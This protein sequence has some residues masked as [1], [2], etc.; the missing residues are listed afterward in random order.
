[1]ENEENTTKNPTAEDLV[2]KPSID[3]IEKRK[4]KLKNF[5]FGWIKDNYDK[6]FIVIIVIAFII[7]FLIFLKTMDQPIWYDTANYLATGKKWGLGLDIRDVWYYRRAFLWPAMAAVIFKIGLGEVSLRFMTVLFSTGIVFVSYFLIKELFS[8]RLAL[9]VSICMS[10][11]W[12]ILFFTAR[13]MTSIPATFFALLAILFFLKG[14]FKEQKTSYMALFGLFYGLAILTRMQYLMLAP[15]FVIFAFFKEKFKFLKNK[16]LWI[17]VIIFLVVLTPHL[18]MYN[19]HY[20][21]PFKDM[22]IKYLGIGALSDNPEVELDEKHDV[23]FS[24]LFKYFF[25]LP[26]VLTKPMLILFIIGVFFFFADLAL[27]IDKVFKNKYLQ[28]KLFVFLIIVVF[29]IV[30]AKVAID[31]VEQRYIMP[32]LPFIFLIPCYLLFKISDDFIHP[33]FPK[34]DKKYL[35]ILVFII[36]IAFLIPNYNFGHQLIDSKKESYREVMQASVWMG[37]NSQPGDMIIS[38]SYMQTQ[39]YSGRTTYTY[40]IPSEMSY[41]LEDIDKEGMTEKEINLK[42]RDGEFKDMREELFH[43]YVM[44]F[45]PTF[46]MLSAYELHPEW[47]YNYPIKHN[48]TWQPVIGFPPSEQ[49]RVVVYKSTYS[50]S[51]EN[52]VV[53]TPIVNNLTDF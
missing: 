26:Y 12:I 35:N 21:N 1:M 50:N 24:S 27:G 28:K 34:L 29:Y 9:A 18:V 15:G 32:V 36:L 49:P 25:D 43:K 39:Y 30:L 42:Y 6:A 37:E 45:K 47:L 38:Q 23:P 5:F 16:R 51:L 4:K 53:D 41:P 19:E 14:Y 8:K 22:A 40:Y 10:A 48:D 20:G 17:S 13:P 2:G 44:E 33:I 52:I 3:S 7:R 11:S 46:L 31:Y